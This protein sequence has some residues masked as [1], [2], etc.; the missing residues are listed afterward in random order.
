MPISLPI[1]WGEE[2]APPE[3]EQVLDEDDKCEKC[4]AYKEA[5]TDLGKI[6]LPAERG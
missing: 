4:D 3:K 5:L 6:W 1:D 2:D